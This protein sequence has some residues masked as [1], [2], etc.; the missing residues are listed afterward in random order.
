[1]FNFQPNFN[2][3]ILRELLLLISKLSLVLSE[4]IFCKIS[5]FSHLLYGPACDLA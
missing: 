1:M 5:I 4:D 2:L 3:G